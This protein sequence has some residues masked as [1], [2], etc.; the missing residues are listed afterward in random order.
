MLLIVH[1]ATRYDTVG[2]LHA[3]YQHIAHLNTITQSSRNVCSLAYAL[4]D[5]LY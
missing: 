5:T 3:N 2:L 4:D 1:C